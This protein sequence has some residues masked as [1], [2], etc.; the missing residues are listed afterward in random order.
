MLCSDNPIKSNTQKQTH[1]YKS[2]SYNKNEIVFYGFMGSF[3]VVF[4]VFMLFFW[5]FVCF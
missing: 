2:D 1:V 4:L 5:L 3:K